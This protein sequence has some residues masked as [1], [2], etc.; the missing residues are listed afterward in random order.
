MPRTRWLLVAVVLLL[1]VIAFVYEN[2]R[3]P[4]RSE[5]WADDLTSAAW[6][7]QFGAPYQVALV[8]QEEWIT[9]PK[10]VAQRAAGYSNEDKIPPKSVTVFPAEDGKLS[11]VVLSRPAMDDS[12][13]LTEWRVDLIQ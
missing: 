6:Q 4:N 12:I 10:L 3:L 13:L 8:D 5:Y 9:D 11:V 1:V 7:K 2:T